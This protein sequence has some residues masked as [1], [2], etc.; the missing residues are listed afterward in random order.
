MCN[1]P[2][3]LKV[4][5]KKISLYP[6]TVLLSM[7]PN[8]KLKEAG[9]FIWNLSHS[10]PAIQERGE[11]FPSNHLAWMSVNIQHLNKEAFHLYDNFS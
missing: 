8:L 4:K 6:F 1:L 3:F 11:V 7:L 2:H 5:A 9:G 10:I